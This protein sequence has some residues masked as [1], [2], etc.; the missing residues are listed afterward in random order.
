MGRTAPVLLIWLAAACGGGG[1]APVDKPDLGDPDIPPLLARV[2]RAQ[3]G[4]PEGEVT[5]SRPAWP[6]RVP[7]IVG[8]TVTS[9]DG[10]KNANAF[11]RVAA[12]GR[13]VVPAGPG[14][15]ARELAELRVLAHGPWDGGLIYIVTAVGGAMPAWPDTLSGQESPL[16]GGGVRITLKLTEATI[17][18]AMAGGAGP[19][20]GPTVGAPHGSGVTPPPPM[21]T[22]TLDIGADYAIHWRYQMGGREFDGPSGTPAPAAPQLTGQQLIT[23]VEGARRRARAPRGM[24]SLEPRLLQNIPDIAEVPLIGL[25]PIYVDLHGAAGLPTADRLTAINQGWASAEAKD[26]VPLLCAVDAL[27]AGL[28]PDDLLPTARVSGGELIAEVSTPLVAW[29]SGGARQISPRVPGIASP[30]AMEQKTRIS[31]RLDRSL[32]WTLGARAR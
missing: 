13:V 22:A 24:P 19:S 5:N 20:P 18:H 1:G 21:G 14:Q 9:K 30:A 26:L 28:V 17:Q 11:V 31:M 10:K 8:L 32:E 4:S 12:G 15:T 23:A 25:G 16:P 27:P 2:A 7:D 3:V 29:A 6:E